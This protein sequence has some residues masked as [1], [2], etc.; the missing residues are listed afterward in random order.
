[1]SNQLSIEEYKQLTQDA[2]VLTEDHYGEKVLRL[3]DGSILKLFRVK[4]WWSSA[5]LHNYAKRFYANAGKLTE[6]NIL[7]VPVLRYL[8]IPAIKRTGVLY[9]PLTGAN[10][11]DIAT[12]HNHLL[13]DELITRIGGLMAELHNK[14]VYFRSLHLGNIILT[15]ENA[16]GIIDI[17]D[18]K[19][20]NN[21]LSTGLRLRNLR[22]LTRYADDLALLQCGQNDLFVAAYVASAK[23]KLTAKEVEQLHN[24]LDKP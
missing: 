11:R 23:P 10:I 15:G 2:E 9:Q 13:N 1:M 7:T 14:G 24:L 8:N 20:H 16:L 19:I 6:K 17:A 22:H 21:P 12:R 4:S 5:L 3:Q 18:I